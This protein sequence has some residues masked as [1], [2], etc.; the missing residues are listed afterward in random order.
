M[1]ELDDGLPYQGISLHHLGAETL[2]LGDII[3]VH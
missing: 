2:V 1:K 3:Q